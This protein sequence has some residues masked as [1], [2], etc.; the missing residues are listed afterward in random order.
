MTDPMM[1][2]EIKS[3]VEK[4]LPE[5]RGDVLKKA[6]MAGGEV[7]LS[8]AKVN[9]NQLFKNS[10]P[11]SGLAGSIHLEVTESNDNQCVVAVGPDKLYGRIQE[12]GGTIRPINGKFLAIP[13]SG[14]ANKYESPKNY[15]G[16]LHFVGDD[17]GGIL[18]DKEGNAIYALKT[19]VT[20]P[21]RPYLRP[22]LDEHVPQIEAAAGEQIRIGIERS[23]NGNH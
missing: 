13:L 6:A 22:A 2:F 21:A 3:D 4:V 5:L 15:P 12:I 10:H 16:K 14:E 23:T 9:A 17:G 1:S 11:G 18:A 20:L 19:S 8:N 7:I